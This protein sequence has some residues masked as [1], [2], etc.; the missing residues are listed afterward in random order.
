[1]MEDGDDFDDWK[2]KWLK[3]PLYSIYALGCSLILKTYK[4]YCPYQSYDTFIC[5]V[6]T[7]YIYVLNFILC[8]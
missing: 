8:S 7:Y 1:M 6:Y 3:I 2:I 5:L 4:K